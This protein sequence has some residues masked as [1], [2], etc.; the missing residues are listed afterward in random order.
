MMPPITRAPTIPMTYHQY[1]GIG[2]GAGVGAGAGVGT[3][4]GAG[5]GGAVTGT[6]LAAPI[7][8]KV[9]KWLIK[10][11]IVLFSVSTTHSSSTH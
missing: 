1:I 6:G 5:A 3:G 4:V 11:V 8:A 9:V 2:V 10:A 7:M